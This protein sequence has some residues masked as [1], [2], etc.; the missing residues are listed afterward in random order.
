MR[1]ARYQPDQS[2]AAPDD[3]VLMEQIERV[4]AIL[5]HLGTVHDRSFALREKEILEG[6]E[7]VERFEQ[8]HKLLGE[9]VGFDVG[10]VEDEGSPDPWWIVG[11]VCLV[12]EDHV[13]A[14]DGSTLDVKKAR[15]VSSHPD[16]M[17]ANVPASQKAKILPVLVTPVKKVSSKAVVHLT[18]VALWPVKDLRQ[19]AQSALATLREVRK[20]FFEP[21]DLTWRERAAELFQENDLSA[22]PLFEKLKK[23]PAA[24]HLKPD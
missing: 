16:W 1:L 13:G 5:V 14:Q 21:G 22:R 23:T 17:Q 10:K 18:G 8:A 15:Q 6:L 2:Q 24:S 4:E 12:F 3:T 11:D 19:W 7:S 9:M 20:T